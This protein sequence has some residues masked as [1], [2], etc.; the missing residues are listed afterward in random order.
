MI[1]RTFTLFPWWNFQTEHRQR[2][3]LLYGGNYNHNTHNARHRVYFKKFRKNAFP[4]RTRQH[5]AVAMTGLSKQR[6]RKMPWPFDISSMIFNQ[7]RAGS[8][9]IGYVVSTVMMKTAIVACNSIVY[10]PK[11]NQR[12]ARVARHFAHDEDLACVDGDLV[13]IKQC[14]FISKYKRYYIFSILEPNIEGRERLKL[15]LPA[16]APALYGYP[17]TRRIVKLNLTNEQNTKQ[18]LA[19]VIQ[20][21]VQ[22]LYRFGGPIGDKPQVHVGQT[23]SMDDAHRLVAPNAPATAAVEGRSQEHPMKLEEFTELEH[24]NRTKKGEEF[25]SRLKQNISGRC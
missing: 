15:G 10:Y 14:R 17:T 21:H 25:F 23:V 8:D 4:N 12:V 9:K 13:H 6:P 2:R 1:R 5:W 3:L 11:Y 18:K 19:T 24:D 20:E 7:A 22:D 16:V